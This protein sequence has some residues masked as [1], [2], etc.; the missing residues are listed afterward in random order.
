MV[1]PENINWVTQKRIK[2]AREKLLWTKVR[3]KGGGETVKYPPDWEGTLRPKSKANYS[4]QFTVLFRVTYRLGE[5]GRQQSR[6]YSLT[7]LKLQLLWDEGH[8]GDDKEYLC[9]P[10]GRLEQVFWNSGQSLH[11]PSK[12]LEHEGLREVTAQTW[13]RRHAK[14]GVIVFSTPMTSTSSAY[15]NVWWRLPNES[16]LWELWGRDST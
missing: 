3:L 2:I 1:S 11:Q 9:V 4:I 5:S 12:S 16:G 8:R 14:D 6:H 13:T 15:S 10:E 7:D